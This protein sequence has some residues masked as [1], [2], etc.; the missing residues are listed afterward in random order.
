MTHPYDTNRPQF[1]DFLAALAVT[2]IIF[3][4]AIGLGAVESVQAPQKTQEAGMEK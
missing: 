1:D 4:L 3:G 2:L